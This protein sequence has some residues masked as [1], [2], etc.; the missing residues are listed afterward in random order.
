M[1]SM[2]GWRGST[3]CS[4]IRDVRS[5]DLPWQAELLALGELSSSTLGALYLNSL[6]LTTHWLDS[7][8]YFRAEALP[9]QGDWG[10]LAVGIGAG[11]P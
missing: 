4:R 9:N 1:P 11:S 10:T 3:S 8:D 5:G 6:G 2:P 7:R